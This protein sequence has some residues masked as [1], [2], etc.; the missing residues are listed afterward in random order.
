[1]D[2]HGGVNLEL[3][4]VLLSKSQIWILLMSIYV[5]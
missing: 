4:S 5:D 2:Q 1:M 3:W